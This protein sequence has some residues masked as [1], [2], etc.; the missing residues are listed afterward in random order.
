MKKVILF[1][2]FI[3][4]FLSAQV[5]YNFETGTLNNWVESVPGRWKADTTR[6][7]SGKYSLH[8]IF[9]NPDSGNDQAGIPVYDLEPS[10][11]LTKWSFKIR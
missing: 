6:S 4:V 5:S 3:P 9:D 2:L 7:L 8:H 10:M 11:G 1:L